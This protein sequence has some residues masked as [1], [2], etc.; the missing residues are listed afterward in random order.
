YSSNDIVGHVWGPDSH[1]VLDITLRSD[2]L[3]ADM[4]D[5]L[6]EKVGKSNYVVA[7]SSDHGVSPLPEM[8]Q[9]QS[10][11]PGRLDVE[12]TLKE[13]EGYLTRQHPVKGRWIEAATG[14]GLYFNRKTMKQA[15]VEQKQIE[16]EVAAWF[17]SKDYVHEVWTR[18]ELMS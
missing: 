1:E 5:Y 4:L 8:Q 2:R 9:K 17:K 16:D 3:M 15:G 14:A 12:L 10:L 13:L 18:T 7:L 6:D 11:K